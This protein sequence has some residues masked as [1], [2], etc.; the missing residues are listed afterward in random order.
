MNNKHPSVLIHRRFF[1]LFV[2]GYIDFFRFYSQGT[3]VYLYQTKKLPFRAVSS[4]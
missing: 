4:Y 2:C 1:V 3:A